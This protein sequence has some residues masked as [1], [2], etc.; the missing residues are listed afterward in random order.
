MLS[1]YA[2]K[3]SN[4]FTLVRIVITNMLRLSPFFLVE[5]ESALMGYTKSDSESALICLTESEFDS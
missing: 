2:K 1:A 5:A 3:I 4:P